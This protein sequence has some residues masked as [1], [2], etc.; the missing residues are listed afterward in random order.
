MLVVELE[1]ELGCELSS[2][3][4]EL[5]DGTASFEPDLSSKEVDGMGEEGSTTV[6]DNAT[7]STRCV[8]ASNS[9][10]VEGRER[11]SK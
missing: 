11:D 3:V 7:L 1:G 2:G 5:I 10:G 4:E 9:H 6:E 8:G